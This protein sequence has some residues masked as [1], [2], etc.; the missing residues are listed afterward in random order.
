MASILSAKD[1]VK[2][3]AITKAIGTYAIGYND[4][5][6]EGNFVWSDGNAS[7]FVNWN[8]KDSSNGSR[9]GDCTE[10]AYKAPFYG[11]W[12]AYNCSL[13]K[14]SICKVPSTSFVI[15]RLLFILRLFI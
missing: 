3:N 5:R 7:K 13:R 9:Q 14:R 15:F 1:Q 10:I 2:I 11:K 4:R 8:N 6:S 12:N